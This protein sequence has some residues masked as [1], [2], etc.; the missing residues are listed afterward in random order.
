M[1]LELVAFAGLLG[2]GAAIFLAL[3]A[4]GWKSE[5]EALRRRVEE[6]TGAQAAA[7]QKAAAAA[8]A[9][10]DKLATE[11]EGLR[12]QL[13]RYKNVLATPTPRPPARAGG[14]EFASGSFAGE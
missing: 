5:V 12:A 7:E 4:S 2:A 13:E 8:K 1:L 9:A 3:Q 14:P 11:V 10:H 6:M